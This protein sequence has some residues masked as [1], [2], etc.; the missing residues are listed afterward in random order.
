MRRGTDHFGRRRV[1]QHC[2]VDQQAVAENEDARSST[3]WQD[4]GG[5]ELGDRRDLALR[6]LVGGSSLNADQQ[7]LV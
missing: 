1:R 5:D 6:F 3:D 4:L 2:N 7:L